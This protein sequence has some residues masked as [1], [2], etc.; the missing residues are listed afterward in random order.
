MHHLEFRKEEKG[1][2]KSHFKADSGDEFIK[3]GKIEHPKR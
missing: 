1:S 3:G 2:T